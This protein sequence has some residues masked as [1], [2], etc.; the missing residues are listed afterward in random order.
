MSEADL[1]FSMLTLPTTTRLF[2]AS[3]QLLLD[4]RPLMRVFAQGYSCG[5]PVQNLRRPPNVFGGILRKRV[6]G[7][8]Q[9]GLSQRPTGCHPVLKAV[10]RVPDLKRQFEVIDCILNIGRGF[11]LV[12]PDGRKIDIRAA[13]IVLYDA[14]RGRLIDFGKKS[15]A[16]RIA[17]STRI[18]DSSRHLRPISR[19]GGRSICS[20]DRVRPSR[21]SWAGLLPR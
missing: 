21:T 6:C 14:P 11:G 12:G 9:E 18:A 3:R 15:A 10:L 20:P 2:A 1:L 8:V 16:L 4:F 7:H 17:G 5:R 19:T 13:K